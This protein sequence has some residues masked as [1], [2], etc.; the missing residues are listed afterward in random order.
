M[1]HVNDI[2]G[3]L[4]GRRDDTN[5]KLIDNV[6]LEYMGVVALPFNQAS[7]VQTMLQEQVGDYGQVTVKV[8][9]NAICAEGFNGSDCRTF[10][11]DM[12]GVLVCEQGT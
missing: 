12:D 6:F 11:Q 4:D 3:F 2:T 8:G 10:C 5:V 1:I 7:F 9:V